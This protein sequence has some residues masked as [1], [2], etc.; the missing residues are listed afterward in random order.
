MNLYYYN[1]LPSK[2][3][4]K[5]SYFSPNL[6][7]SLYLNKSSPIYKVSEKKFYS[8]GSKISLSQV[9][10]KVYVYNGLRFKYLSINKWMVGFKFGEFTWNRKPAIFKVKR[11]KK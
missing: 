2:N 9:G 5:L 6:I 10:Q 1:C 7:R 4:R 8:R 3:K 11:K